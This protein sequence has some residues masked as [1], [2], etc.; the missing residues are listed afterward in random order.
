MI[1]GRKVRA[2]V[3]VG[4]KAVLVVAGMVA[5]VVLAL[6]AAKY[7]STRVQATPEAEIHPDAPAGV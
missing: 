1:Q 6:L 4:C 7:P 5:V 2:V 3:V